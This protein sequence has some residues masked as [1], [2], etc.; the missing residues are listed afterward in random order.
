[1][2]QPV[3]DSTFALINDQRNSLEKECHDPIRV[4]CL[5][6]G[7]GESEYVWSK[8]REYIRETLEG[9][10]RLV[11]D[12]RPWSSVVRGACMRGLGSQVVLTKKS[13]FWYGIGVH[14]A[15]EEGVDDEADAFV[16]AFGQKRARGYI[17][18]VVKK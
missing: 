17:D 6:G 5:C 18:W 9:S 8:F 13:K 12:Q 2:F 7:L 16:D 10:C 3:L 11:R 14:R 1:M 15:F 4:I